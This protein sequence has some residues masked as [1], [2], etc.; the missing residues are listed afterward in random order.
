MSA[1][2]APAPPGESDVVSP[3]A[4]D[5]STS[6]VPSVARSRHPPRRVASTAALIAVAHV[7]RNPAAEP[8]SMA[9]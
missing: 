3:D 8:W 2:H 7:A 1:P 5:A 9:G 4:D 6:D